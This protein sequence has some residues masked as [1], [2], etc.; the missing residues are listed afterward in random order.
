[1]FCSVYME[2]MNQFG[3][4]CSQFSFPLVFPDVSKSSAFRFLRDKE[5]KIRDEE[6]VNTDVR[7][8]ERMEGDRSGF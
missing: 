4:V 1:M 8:A 7:T 5:R 3:F 6:K 2:W